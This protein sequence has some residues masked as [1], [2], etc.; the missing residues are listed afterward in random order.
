MYMF[1][2][3]DEKGGGFG[4]LTSCGQ[5]VMMDTTKLKQAHL[6]YLGSFQG[7]RFEDSD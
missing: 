4:C 5:A 7:L 6:L 1:A 2:F 3:F